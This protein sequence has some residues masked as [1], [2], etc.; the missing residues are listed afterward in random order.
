MPSSGKGQKIRDIIFTLVLGS[1][2]LLSSFFTVKAYHNN[3]DGVLLLVVGVF[4]G[5]ISLLVLTLPLN[6][7]RPVNALHRL[8]GWCL[9][10]LQVALVFFVAFFSTLFTI[11]VVF[12]AINAIIRVVILAVKLFGIHFDIEVLRTSVL[13][14]SALLTAIISAYYG[15]KVM[16]KLHNVLLDDGEMK[17]VTKALALRVF[18]LIDFRRR[19]YEISILLYAISVIEKMSE[20][21]LTD[22]EIWMDYKEVT[23]EVLLS[24]VAIDAYVRNYLR[25]KKAKTPNLRC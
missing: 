8:L 15:D 23:L 14:L 22:W 18:R 17:E 7:F 9:G 11:T 19:V 13:Y 24:F 2:L 4:G 3:R 5:V 6:R 10:I 12:F 16:L 20:T 21:V 25:T 1:I